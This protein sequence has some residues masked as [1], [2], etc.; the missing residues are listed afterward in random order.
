MEVKP[1]RSESDY[2]RVLR[3]VENLWGSPQGTAEGDELDVLVTLVEAYERERYPIDL[4]DPIDA[5][6]FRLEQ[7]GKSFGALVGI[8]GQ[9]TRVYEVMRGDR[10]LSLNMIRKLHEELEIPAEVLIQ[11]GRWRPGR[12][13]HHRGPA[14]PT[15]RRAKLRKPA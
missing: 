11:P 7:T 14:S 3:R 5:I 4:P 9:R 15:G 6:K 8:I 10:P 2:E 12:R 1:I 13:R